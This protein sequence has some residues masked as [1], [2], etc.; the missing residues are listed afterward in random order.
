M[1]LGIVGLGRMGFNMAKRLLKSN[2]EVVVYNRTIEKTKDIETFGATGSCSIDDFVSKLKT[3]RIVWLMLPSGKITEEHIATLSTKLIEGDILIEGGN[4]NYTDDIKHYSFL[5]EKGIN[6]IDAGVSGGIWGYEN[7]YCTMIGGDIQQF[8][9][10]EPILKDLAPINGYLYCG[11]SGAGHYVKMIHNAI[12]YALM[13]AYGEGF[14]ILKASKYGQNLDLAKV[15]NLWNQGS[16]VRSWILELLESAFLKDFNLSK[17]QGYVED[18][19]ETRFAVKEAVDMGVSVPAIAHSL[20]KRFQ[21]RQI[22][23]FSNKIVA[24]LRSEF[25]GHY[26]AS[27]DEN[28]KNNIFGA[29][30]LEH[31]K[32]KI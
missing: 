16:V 1:Q 11:S 9:H 17:I 23:A 7:G 27:V 22:N 24:A 31:A 21:S 3:P 14:E 25:G 30:V 28:I 20:F 32:P 2:H 6:Y 5:K 19:G 26:T 12:E 18:S 8:Q 4:S 13:E 10:I 29:G 15:A